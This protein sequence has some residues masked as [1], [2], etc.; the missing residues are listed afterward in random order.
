M[1]S[2]LGRF[3]FKLLIHGF[4]NLGNVETG[5]RIKTACP[6]K[7]KTI[8]LATHKHRFRPWRLWFLR[9]AEVDTIG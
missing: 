4:R 7:G 8:L 1:S 5:L 6:V 2:I 3:G 9:N